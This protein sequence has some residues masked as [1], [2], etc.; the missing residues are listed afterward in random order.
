MAMLELAA[1]RDVRLEACDIEVKRPGP[2]YTIDTLLTL[3]A[4]R[5]E[6]QLYLL[7]GLDAYLE[8]D[9][10][11]RSG[12]LLDHANIVVTTRPGLN[13]PSAARLEPPFAARDACCYDPSIGCHVHSSGHTLRLHQLR[14]GVSVSA[15]LVR[16][17]IRAGLPVDGLVENDVAAYI[18]THRLYRDPA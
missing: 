10:W 11:E 1:A 17:R 8:I 13:A 7:L 2:S 16:D 12:Q 5:P 15:S 14:Y 9:S 18:D 3:R 4:T 6:Q